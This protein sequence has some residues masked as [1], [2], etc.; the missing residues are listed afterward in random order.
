M[1]LMICVPLDRSRKQLIAWMRIRLRSRLSLRP[2]PQYWDRK[3]VTESAVV[4][5]FIGAAIRI[6]ALVCFTLA[7]VAAEAESDFGASQ[8]SP[9]ALNMPQLTAILNQ[10]ATTAPYLD[11]YQ[12]T[13]TD[14]AGAVAS[15]A[16]LKVVQTHDPAHP[17]L[18]VFHDPV[19]RTKFATYAAYSSDLA[20]WHT[21]G[22]IDDVAAGDYGAQPDIRILGDDSVLLAEE[23]NPAHRPQIRMRYYGKRGDQSGLQGF[24]ADPGM[25]PTFQKVLPN[26]GPFSRADGT[27]EFGRIDYAGAI[28]HSKIEIT[29][30]YFDLGK[31]DIEADG[32]LT[33]GQNWS[34]AT[35]EAIN[36][37]VT[38]AGGNGKIGDRELFEVGSSAY[39][40]VEAQ[41]D[42]TSSND[43]GSWRLFLVNRNAGAIQKLSPKLAGGAQSLGNPTV[44]FVDLPKGGGP[45]LIFTCFVFSENAGSTPPGGHTYVYRL[46]N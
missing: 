41:V 24:I 36:D 13:T 43:F 25:P 20:Q 46:A 7:S 34:D 8:I 18:G 11:L 17:Y 5:P 28:S 42:P 14:A 33:N 40:V 4:A 23:Y 30:H 45:A 2:Q 44:T 21:L 31:R 10:I 32:T 35:D 27:P 6:L 29:H 9:V 1:E 19:T 26:I 15:L 16:P 39:E 12:L 38:K 22:R 3:L 37:L